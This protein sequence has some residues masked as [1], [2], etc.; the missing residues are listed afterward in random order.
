MN[1]CC[2]N[3]NIKLEVKI[4]MAKKCET[5][6]QRKVKMFFEAGSAIKRQHRRAMT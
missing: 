1:S 4:Q 2:V 5:K 3:E 6:N